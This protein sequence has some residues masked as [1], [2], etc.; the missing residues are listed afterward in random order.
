M[1]LRFSHYCHSIKYKIYRAWCR[2]CGRVRGLLLFSWRA[3]WSRPRSFAGT[4]RR[5]VCFS[6]PFRRFRVGADAGCWSGPL[7]AES[8]DSG[9]LQFTCGVVVVVDQ[10]VRDDGDRAALLGQALCEVR[11]HQGRIVVAPILVGWNSTNRP[12]RRIYAGQ[13]WLRKRTP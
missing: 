8:E 2:R 11:V 3:D 5:W 13:F 10:Q 7:W 6:N 9:F 1:K 4:V 12:Y